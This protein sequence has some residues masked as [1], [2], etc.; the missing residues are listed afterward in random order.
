MISMLIWL[1]DWE[2]SE[3]IYFCVFLNFG[4]NI[5]FSI[6][7]ESVLEILVF[8]LAIFWIS[9]SYFF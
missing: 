3:I 4:Y 5:K 9:F 1:L 2:I 6:C 7:F 8:D